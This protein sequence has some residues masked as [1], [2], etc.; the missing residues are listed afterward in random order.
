MKRAIKA[1][2]P[3]FLAL[4][5][6]FG[7]LPASAGEAPFPLTVTDQGG[8]AV[9]IPR[10]PERIV[11]GY[12]IS[13]SACI[14]LGLEDRLAGIETGAEKRNIYALA[15]PG[16]LDLPDVGSAKAFDLEGCAALGPD[17][18]IL[19]LRL[20][21]AADALAK[22]H[23]PAILVNP[24][25]HAL[26]TEA[27]S[28]IAKAAGVPERSAKLLDAYDE[29]LGRAAR[30]AGGV[31]RPRVLMAG[32]SS[33]LSCAPG[34]MYQSFL[35]EAAGGVNAAAD[36]PGTGWVQLSYEQLLSLDPEYLLLPPE[37]SYSASDLTNDP[38]LR[39]LSAVREGRVYAMPSAFEP[40]DAPVPSGI[41]GT[42]WTLQV[43]HGDLYGAEAFAADAARF[44]ETF[45]GFT[46]DRELLAGR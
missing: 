32:N 26:L 16:L 11:S 38:Q 20:R 14:A 24:E 30:L 9:E 27:V 42:L 8:R 15:A 40:W 29:A 5:L 10:E 31:E 22:L 34:G 44:Y 7:P 19:P 21:D 1:A 17:L 35:I 23:I 36:L 45:Y 3:L 2:A 12:Y 18:V 43:L 13:S 25:S 39:P 41:L 4:V 46:P 28:L 33:Y 37:R 6:A